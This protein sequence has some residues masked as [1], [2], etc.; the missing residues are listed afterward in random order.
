L[1][2]GSGRERDRQARR[3]KGAM[4]GSDDQRRIGRDRGQKIEAR[5]TLALIG[6]KR[7]IGPMRE[8]HHMQ[9][10][11]AHDARPASATAIRATSTAATSSFDCGGHDSTPPAVIRCT[12]LRSPPMIPV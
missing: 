7:Q 6:G 10:G 5:R 9:P 3:N 1:A 12:R 8:P 4:T 11:F 2:L